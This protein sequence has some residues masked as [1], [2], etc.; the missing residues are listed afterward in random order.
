M[1]N[2]AKVIRQEIE[3]KRCSHKVG[4]F[5]KIGP[6]RFDLTA[7]VRYLPGQILKVKT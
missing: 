7:V 6:E 5:I 3:G 4:I 1:L 2:S